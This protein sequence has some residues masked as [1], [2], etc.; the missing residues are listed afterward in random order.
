MRDAF[1]WG[2]IV[3]LSHPR[4]CKMQARWALELCQLHGS[5]FVSRRIVLMARFSVAGR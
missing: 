5:T 2:A 1:P 3:A 4:G